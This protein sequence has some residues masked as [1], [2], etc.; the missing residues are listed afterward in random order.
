MRVAENLD[1][2]SGPSRHEG[3]RQVV[4]ADGGID[5]SDGGAAGRT[6]DFWSDVC[7]CGDFAD[8]CN[9]PKS[10]RY[11]QVVSC[12]RTVD[13]VVPLVAGRRRGVVI[14]VIG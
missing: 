2:Q 14:M 6:V 7:S 11:C 5:G 4:E 9:I 3:T 13:H 8:A 12:F 10:V 1:H